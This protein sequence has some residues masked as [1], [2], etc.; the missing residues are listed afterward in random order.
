MRPAIQ[1]HWSHPK[2]FA[3]LASHLANLPAS[4]AD[5]AAVTA[6]PDLPMAV[7]C[8]GGLRPDLQR[9]HER[10]ATFSPSGRFVRASTTGHWIQLDDPA[11]VVGLIREVVEEVQ[12]QRARLDGA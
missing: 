6:F 12:R 8:A 5:A 1:A 4:A 11:L 10:L 2:S 3:S 7:V 9:Q